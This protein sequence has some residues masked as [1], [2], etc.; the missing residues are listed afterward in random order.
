[1]PTGNSGSWARILSGGEVSCG[2]G[3]AHPRA[4]PHSATIQHR[5]RGTLPHA[6]P[7]PTWVTEYG[8]YQPAHPGGLGDNSDQ[9]VLELHVL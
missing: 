2:L 5:V 4:K 1:M 3:S 9:L 8:R 6:W 7:P